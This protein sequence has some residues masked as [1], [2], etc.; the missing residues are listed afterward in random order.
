MDR[1]AF[2]GRMLSWLASATLFSA[3]PSLVLQSMAGIDPQLK[4]AMEQWD[5]LSLREM[6]E[7]KVHHGNSRFTNPFNLFRRRRFVDLLKWKFFGNNRFRHLYAQERVT[8]VS[9]DWGPIQ[10]HQGLSVTF[11]NH[12]SVLIRDRGTTFLIDPVFYGLRPFCKDFSPLRFD[13]AAM[14]SPDHILI[15]HGHYDHLDKESL[16]VFHKKTHV[17]TPL[18]YNGVFRSL[19][20]NNRTQLDWYGVYENDRRRV[21]L[22]P[23]NHWTMRNPFIGPNR[24]LWGSYLVQTASGPTLFFS[25]DTAYFSG[26]RDIGHEFNI[27]LAVFNLGAYE[28]RWFM[29]QSHINPAETLTAFEE[30]GAEKLLAVHWG[31]FRLGDEPVFKPPVDLEEE[32]ARRNLS[33]RIVPLAHG[34]TLY[35]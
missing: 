19:G 17:V 35:L 29:R 33:G 26:F 3:M 20:M 13:P 16:K 10:R 14:P 31:T 25:G 2:L 22:L 11:I 4:K 7:K 9:I 12:A 23:C 34:Q 18:G 21:V 5:G 6:A 1:R 28:P 27:D 15:T 32:A 30:L 24:S 8:P